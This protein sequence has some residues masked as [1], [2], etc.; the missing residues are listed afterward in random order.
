MNICEY[1]DEY[2]N[3]TFAEQPFNEVDSLIF[4][5]LAYLNWDRFVGFSAPEKSLCDLSV[6]K[7]ELI[8][9]VYVPKDNLALIKSAATSAR[10]HNIKVGWFESH[11][12]EETTVQFAAVTFKL[13]DGTAVVAFRGTDESIVGWKEDFNMA[14][15]SEIP[16]QGLAVEYLNKVAAKEKHTLIVCGHSKGGNLAVYASVFSKQDVKNRIQ[17]IYNHDGPGFHENIFTK[18]EYIELQ[19]KIYKFVPH[20]SL[21][22]VLLEHTKDFNVVQ[23]KSANIVQ[24]IPFTWQVKDE[25]CFHAKRSTTVGSK[26]VDKA[27]SDFVDGMDLDQ[28]KSFVNGMFAVIEG[29]GAKYLYELRTAPL[30]RLNGMRKA[31]SAL[32]G[33][34]KKLMA[35]GGMKFIKLWFQSIV[36]L[37]DEE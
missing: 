22:G 10:F 36:S 30:S 14:F 24:H 20:D 29:S 35:L 37:K 3:K 18:Q 21:I 4:A 33:D 2:G 34:E 27:M 32:T 25:T 6:H 7:K 16:A 31:Y 23:C 12:D 17:A 9:C 13:E 28:R 1:L 19:D 15:L 11:Y 8:D 5:E 26:M